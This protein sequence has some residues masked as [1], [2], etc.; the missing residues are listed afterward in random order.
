MTS[1]IKPSILLKRYLFVSN[2][3]PWYWN[4]SH[5][6]QSYNQLFSKALN[7]CGFSLYYCWLF[8]QLLLD[9]AKILF[10][11]AILLLAA[12][13]W[14]T[15]HAIFRSTLQNSRLLTLNQWCFMVNG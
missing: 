12:A 14:P 9:A 6:S 15:D 3:S 8:A 13:K 11:F 1:P 7:D 10:D 4:S 5:F 2:K